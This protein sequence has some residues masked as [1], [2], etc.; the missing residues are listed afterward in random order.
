[1]LMLT[2]AGANAAP[3]ASTP[4]MLALRAQDWASAGRIASQEGDAGLASDLVTFIRLLKP[5]QATPE[6]IE[7]FLKAHLTWPD[8][9]VLLKRL[10]EAV[11]ADPDDSAVAAICE[12][13]HFPAAPLA[14]CADAYEAAGRHK[15]AAALAREAWTG[16]I[17][18]P[19]EAAGFLARWAGVLTAEDEWRRFQLLAD[20]DTA[21][22]AR[23]IPRL[24][25]G[26]RQAA[27]ARLAWRHDDPD[28]LALLAAVPEALR[29]DP[30]LVLENARSLRRTGA[31][32]AAV[33]LWHD[34]GSTAEASVQADARGPFWA[35][36][37]TLARKLLATGDDADAA[38][39]AGDTLLHGDQA[40]DS[41]FLSGWIALRR[42]HDTALALTR[43]RA[44]AAVSHSAITRARAHYWL[45]RTLE[46]AANPVAAHA[47]YASAATWYT[48]YY[49]QLAGEALGDAETRLRAAEDPAWTPAQA[50]GFAGLNPARAAELLVRWGDDLR[51]RDF[52]LRLAETEPEAA[53]QSWTA[54]LA[55]R[56]QMPAVAVQIAR[57]AGRTGVMLPDAGWPIPLSIPPD[58]APLVLAIM[59]QESNF[60]PL[61]VSPAG[62]RGLMQVMPATARV[63]AAAHADLF[64][65]AAN[66]RVG[67]AYLQHLLDQ[68]SDEPALAAAAYNAGPNRVRAWLAA[69]SPAPADP[70]QLI[71]WVELIPFAET[72]NYVQR[73]LEGEKIFAAKLR[74]KGKG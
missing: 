58:N 57:M 51:A 21:A 6:E 31:L 36:R 4:M 2:F 55:L 42:T 10:G 49:G 27:L 44:L 59:R 74:Q 40:A 70:K 30:A 45:A 50:L 62:A 1:M 48:T 66:T 41:L 18:D 23:E 67:S 61:V 39:L 25:P 32:A 5:G 26:H 16:G 7:A 9:P 29:S 53:A 64:D 56:L 71:D 54:H 19:S 20:T 47:E 43:L 38:F 37:D 68:F 22:A 24:D 72:R 65:P 3:A 34:A 33:L 46:D 15:Q 17:T 60:D 28:A 73:V 63:M 13:Q 11:I 35:E 69:D 8:R 52:L 14:R 12:A